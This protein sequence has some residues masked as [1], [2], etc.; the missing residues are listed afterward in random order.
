[1]NRKLED[2]TY[3]RANQADLEHKHKGAWNYTDLNRICNNLKYAAE[4]MYDEG[5]LAEPYVMQIK[6]D[7][8]ETDIITYEELNTMIVNNMNNLK[9]FSRPD[10]T[11]HPIAMLANIDY[12]VANWLERNI[13]ELAHQV[14]MPAVPHKLTVENGYGSGEY[15]AG[16]VIEIEA[17]P[18]P[19]EG[20]VFDHWSGN[21]LESVEYV[22][23]FRTN[24]TMPH[25]DCVL[26][27][28]YSDKIPHTFK[29]VTHTK[30]ET[31]ELPAG[32]VYKLEA[33]PAPYG[34]VFHHWNITPKEHEEHL[35]E[36]AATT[37]FTMPNE[38]VTIKA[39]YITR[40]EKQL[41]VINGSGSGWYEYGTYVSVGSNKPVGA[42]FTN[43]SG[44]TQY[45]TLDP[46]EE[47]NVVEIPDVS[48]IRIQANWTT[49]SAP[50][51]PPSDGG[52]TPDDGGGGGVITPPA[53]DLLLTVVNGVIE[54]TGE[55]TGIY[56]QGDRV[57]I[58]ADPI[59]S[60]YTFTGWSLS[61]S[62]S[63]LNSALPTATAAIG[64]GDMTA[65]AT[66]RKLEYY[67]L[68]VTTSAGTETRIIES[69]SGFSL[70]AG[71]D[72]EGHVFEKW[73][74]DIDGISYSHSRTP[75]FK[76]MGNADRTIEAY[77]RP[78]ESHT[79]TVIQRSNTYAYTQI[80]GT[81]VIVTPEPAPSRSSIQRLGA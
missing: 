68:T 60:G 28:N 58:V 48:L 47:F 3:A 54:E 76:K 17:Y 57:R 29:V 9:T 30:S 10:L 65:T 66:Y 27:A 46:T 50:P 32:A 24:F 39:V 36:P 70:D 26:T 7:W 77:Y 41:Q 1:M 2:V 22:T 23:A 64:S 52:T 6:T 25:E 80:E 16:T 35:Y 79:L 38:A 59:P 75:S 63:I 72:P 61:G 55:H 12:S 11:W 5:F 78:L 4:H 43:W 18:P 53:T 8:K 21:H 74:G 44:D 20:L 40:G 19:E 69:E 33:D 42:R 13:D 15:L 71:E 56:D 73:T 37:H 14:P 81:T 31:L 34:K 67:T 45:L 49:P 51:T 62:G